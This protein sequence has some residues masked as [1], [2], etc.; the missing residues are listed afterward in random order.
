M[1]IISNA[2]ERAVIAFVNG[3]LNVSRE[4]GEM[5][6]RDISIKKEDDED[7]SYH[8]CNDCKWFETVTSNNVCHVCNE[9]DMWESK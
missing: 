1:E 3:F 4:D 5:A 9:K 8:S 7:K 6:I 2:S